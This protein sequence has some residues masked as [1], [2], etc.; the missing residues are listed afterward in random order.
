[1]MTAFIR[2]E[3]QPFGLIAN[4]PWTLGGAIGSEGAEKAA[5]FL[6]LCDAYGL[7]IVSLVDTPGFMVGPAS[8]ETAAVRRGA[9][10]VAV[11]ANLS[12]PLFAVVVRKGY[13]LGAQAMAGGSFRQPVLTMAWP[14]A[15]FGAMGI[16]GAVRLGFSK[17]L[18]A[19]EDQKGLEARLIA[20]MYA[21][22]AAVSVAAHLEI[23]AV[24]DPFDTRAV[25][26]RALRTAGPLPPR[27]RGFVD[28]W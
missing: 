2:I 21:R 13:G 11:G 16:E 27:R 8:E 9:R 28:V 14:T 18:A 24:I 12:V 17:E 20:A 4:N 1:M 6:Q 5:R 10:L 23:D 15:E 25:I 3:G 22:G 19:S 26:L 7:P